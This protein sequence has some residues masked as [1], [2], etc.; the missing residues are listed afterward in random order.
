MLAECGCRIRLYW[1]IELFQAVDPQ[2]VR[3]S[4]KRISADP[5]DLEAWMLVVKDAQTR[6]IDDSRETFE[7]LIK[8]FPTSGRFWKIYIEQEV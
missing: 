6:R 8:L 1:E 5:Y 4:L 7:A 3:N 2:R